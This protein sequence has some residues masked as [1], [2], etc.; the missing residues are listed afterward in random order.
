MPGLRRTRRTGRAL[1]AGPARRRRVARIDRRRH[2]GACRRR[3]SSASSPIRATAANS[4]TRGPAWSCCAQDDAAAVAGPALIATRSLRRVREDRGTVRAHAR[5]STPGIHPSAVID[6]ERPGDRRARSIGP[7][8]SIGA[9]SAIGAGAVVGPGCVIGDD[10]DRRRRLRAD[11]A[12]HPGHARAPGQARADPSRRG[13]RRR[14]L[15]PGDG[16]RPLDQGAATGRRGRSATIARSA[17]TPPSTAARSTTPCSRRTCAS[18]TRSRS[19]TT[20]ASARIPRWPAA[21]AVAGSAR[22]GRYCLIGGGAGIAR[23]PGNLR[24]GM[25]TAMSL[26]THSIREPGEYSSGTPMRTIAPGARNAARFKQLD[27][28]GA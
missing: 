14:R 27:A 25:V 16:R 4:P 20:C 26:V 28:P 21:S 2:A 12:G 15:R 5:A 11:G 9:R 1:R 24:P 18:T 13:A 22:I 17:P 6:A 10:C 8:A 7:F 3:A 23:P 19:A